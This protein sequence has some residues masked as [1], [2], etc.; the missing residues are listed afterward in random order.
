MELGCVEFC[1]GNRKIF[2]GWGM[3]SMLVDGGGEGERGIY[4]NM[5]CFLG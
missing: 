5:C 1:W 4:S 2:K 3:K